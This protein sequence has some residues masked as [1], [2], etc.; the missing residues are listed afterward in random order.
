[1]PVIINVLECLRHDRSL[2]FQ[3]GIGYRSATLKVGF[4][5]ENEVEFHAMLTKKSQAISGVSPEFESIVEELYPSIACTGFG[6]FLNRLYECIPTKIWGVK[7]SHIFALMTSPLGALV[8]L[9]LKV[10]GSR[11]VVTNR[12]VKRMK[13]LGNRL[14]ESVSLDQ[15][16]DV[17]IDPDSRQAFYR[18]GDVRLTNAAGDTLLLLR[19]VPYPERFQQV[20]LE[21]RDARKQVAS[22]LARIQARK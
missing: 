16:S 10:G 19:G 5:N 21:M 7:I 17:S 3:A 13:S 22:S 2:V 15:V 12:N 11:Y 20:V 1:M 8:Y 18:T 6:E 14:I 4:L 9:L